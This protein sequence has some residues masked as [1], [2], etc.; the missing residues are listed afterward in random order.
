M[1][2]KILTPRTSPVVTPAQLAS[3][4]KFDVPQSSPVSTDYSEIQL[5]IEAATDQVETIAQTACLQEQALLTLDFFPNTQDPRA[6]EQFNLISSASQITPWWYYGMP[7]RDS[8]E[9]VRRPVVVPTLANSSSTVTSVSVSGNIVTVTCAN[10]FAPG[11]VVVLAGTAE[12]NIAQPSL[13]PSTTPFLNGVPLTVLTASGTQFTAAFSFYTLSGANVQVPTSYTNNSDTGTAT[14][15]NNPLVITYN[16]VNGVLQTWN[17]TNYTVQ[18][19]KVCLAV[20]NWWPLTDRRQDCI[21]ISYWAGKTTSPASVDNRLQMAVRYLANH[22]WNIRDIVTV[23]PTS[24]IFGT[25]CMM[26]GVYKTYRIPR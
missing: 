8:I 3:F 25:L 7:T 10:A 6:L 24:E 19:D 5:Y 23:E 21:Q 2:Q 9:L 15:V 14:L 1:F 20:G 18:Y 26:L 13:T 11:N 22:M 12:G 4:G 16:D 17:T